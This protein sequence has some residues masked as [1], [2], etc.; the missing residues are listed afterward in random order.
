MKRIVALLLM[1]SIV[2]C[3]CSA[4]SD[5]NITE[6]SNIAADEQEI[7]TFDEENEEEEA[8]G[9][10]I[11]FEKNDSSEGITPGEIDSISQETAEHTSQTVYRTKYGE[12]YHN[13]WCYYLKSKIETTVDEAKARGLK[14]CSKCNPPQ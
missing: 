1:I 3:G 11:L 2:L 10:K 13:E 4:V 8:P 14:P 9:E 6:D 7:L 5:T 12:K